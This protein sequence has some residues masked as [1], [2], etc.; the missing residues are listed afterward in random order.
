M[1][2]N[3]T[4]LKPLKYGIAIVLLTVIGNTDAS[5]QLGKRIKD[6]SKEKAETKT[7]DAVD[8]TID[9]SFDKLDQGINKIFRFRL[10]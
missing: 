4:N 1:K 10:N 8:R 6:R 3:L 7:E 5:A 9:K 2:N